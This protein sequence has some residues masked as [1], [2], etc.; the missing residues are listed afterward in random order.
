M[1]DADW[2]QTNQCHARF[3]SSGL[4]LPDIE[5]DDDEEDDDAV[6]SPT[7]NKKNPVFGV[8]EKLPLLHDGGGDA[9]E[10]IGR[11]HV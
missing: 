1:L 5:D 3:T 8:G 7:G 6:G 11:A 2:C 9:E 10:E 4:V